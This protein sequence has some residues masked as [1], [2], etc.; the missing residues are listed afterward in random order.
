MRRLGALL[1]M[2]A[3]AGCSSFGGGTREDLPPP[4][5]PSAYKADVGVRVAWSKSLGRLPAQTGFALRPTVVGDQVFVANAE[6]RVSA[7]AV[8]T[9]QLVWQ[10]ELERPLSAGPAA[11]G[12]LVVVGARDGEAIGLQAA[13]GEILWRSGVTSEVLAA[14]A[15]D[16]ELVVVRV[17][18]G[19]VFGLDAS[20]GRRRW[21]YEQTVPALALRGTSSPLLVPGRLVVV[22]L[23][24]GKLVALAPDSGRPLW[25]AIVATPQ[26]RSDLERLVDIDADPLLYRT[27]IYVASYNG[28]LA[29]IDAASGRTRWDRELSVLAGL[30]VDSGRVYAT[31]AEQRVWAFDRFSGASVWRQDDLRGLQRLTGPAVFGDYVLVGD[32]AGYLNWLSLRDGSLQRRQKIGGAF[33]AAPMVQNDAIYILTEKGL[34]VLR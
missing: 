3:L 22:G 11:A 23:D 15:V 2:L 6:G 4:P 34:T 12:D 26:G 30:A 16:T 7:L 18:D 1:L 32:D 28:R 9:G 31:D 20:S 14:P 10:R 29:A 13:D 17:A 25:E 8:D 19:R 5:S 33:V 27:D 21:L 24:T